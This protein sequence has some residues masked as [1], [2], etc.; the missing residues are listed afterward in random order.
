MLADHPEIRTRKPTPQRLEIHS[1]DWLRFQRS[2]PRRAVDPL[3]LPAATV[4]AMVASIQARKEA[5]RHE[6]TGGK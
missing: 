3:D 6:K 4:D 1:A 5:I 2:R